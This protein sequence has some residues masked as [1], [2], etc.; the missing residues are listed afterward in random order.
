MIVN[1]K[2]ALNGNAL[3]FFEPLQALS[4]LHYDMVAK[5][6]CDYLVNG[7]TSEEKLLGNLWYRRMVE[8]YIDALAFHYQYGSAYNS[9]YWEKVSKKSVTRVAHKWWNDGRLIKSVAEKSMGDLSQHP[10]F[11]Y[12]P[13]H[14]HIFGITCMEQLYAGL[15]GDRDL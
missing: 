6:I 13:D 10:D 7:Q 9:G 5:R 12:A 4:L 1:N 15:S 3:L 11:Y 2:L 14:T 8:A